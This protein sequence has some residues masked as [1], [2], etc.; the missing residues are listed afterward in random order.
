LTSEVFYTL[1]ALMIAYH[2]FSQ[3]DSDLLKI[4]LHRLTA[5]S[6]F[7]NVFVLGQSIGGS[8]DLHAL[9]SEGKL[10]G[11]LER[12]RVKVNRDIGAGE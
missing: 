12:A 8:D 2:S 9:H 3:D 5:R 10:K 6:T 7:P 11:I 4:I 1:F